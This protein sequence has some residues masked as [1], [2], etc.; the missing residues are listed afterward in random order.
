MAPLARSWTQ[1]AEMKVSGDGFVGQG[2]SVAERCYM[3]ER[4]QND[5][6]GTCD[7]EIFASKESPVVNLA[8]V[9][10]NWGP[11]DA[12]LKLD[13]TRTTRSK[14][15]RFGHRSNLDGSTDLIVWIRHEGTEAISIKL[16]P[17]EK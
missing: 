8:F 3:I 11:A 16:T 10:K 5:R 2:Y 1:P 12:K 4:Q 14:R 7:V 15:F 9:I 13:G 17:I 6:G